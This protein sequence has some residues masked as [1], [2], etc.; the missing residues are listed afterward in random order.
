MS[1]KRTGEKGR[2]KV[3]N[4]KSDCLFSFPAVNSYEPLCNAPIENAI[5]SPSHSPYALPRAE[6]FLDLG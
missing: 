3:L 1:W 2:E 6:L 4:I 5:R